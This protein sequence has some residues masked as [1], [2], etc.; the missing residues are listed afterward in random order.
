[1]FT[2]AE[3]DEFL[4]RIMLFLVEKSGGQVVLTAKDLYPEGKRTF[5]VRFEPE[6]VEGQTEIDPDQKII[7]SV[8]ATT[9]EDEIEFESTETVP[10]GTVLN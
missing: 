6:F 9:A 2:D 7:V 4:S 1:M 3:H 8:R 5:L 10:P